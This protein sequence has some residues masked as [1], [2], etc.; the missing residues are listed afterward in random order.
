MQFLF[1]ETWVYPQARGGMPDYA[2]TSTQRDGTSYIGSWMYAMGGGAAMDY[3]EKTRE[4]VARGGDPAFDMSDFRRFPKALA[5]CNFQIE[6]RVAGLHPLGV[7]DVNGPN[8]PYGHW[9]T[10]GPV[11]KQARLG[12][13]WTRDPKYAYILANYFG[14]K[15]ESPEDWQ[16]ILEAAK[17]VANPW[18]T[19]RSRVLANWGALLEGGVQHTD[20]RYRRAAQIRV[21]WGWGHQHND[22]LDLILWCHGVIHAAVGG[23]RPEQRQLGDVHEPK[24]QAS[25]TH[26]MVEIDGQGSHGTGQHRGYSW[27][28]D[29]KD[30]EGARYTLCE[31]FPSINHPYQRLYRRQAAL[32]DLNEGTLPDRQPET[33]AQFAPSWKLPKALKTPDAYVFDVVRVA[34]GKRHTYCFHGCE[35]DEFV[36]NALNVRPVGFTYGAQADPSPEAKYLNKFVVAESKTAGVAPKVLEATWRLQREGPEIALTRPE[37]DAAGENQPV[38]KKTMKRANTEQRILGPNYDP[39]APRK[40]TRLMLFDREGDKVLTGKWVATSPNVT[41]QC[42]FAQRDLP[43]EL[44]E[45]QPGN[46]ESVYPAVIE[47]Y[48]GT[49]VIASARSVEIQDNESDALRAAA[50][51]LTLADGRKD[52]CFSGGRA[53]RVRRL[54]GGMTASADFAYLSTDAAGLRQAQVVGGVGLTHPALV[55]LAPVAAQR[56]GKVVEV[57]YFDKKIVVEGMAVENAALLKGA[58]VE[59]GHADHLTSYTVREASVAGRRVTLTL[60]KGADFYSSRVEDVNAATG[61]VR[62]GLGFPT[63]DSVVFPGMS[64]GLVASNE[65]LTRFWRA[66]FLG[67]TREE[68]YSFKLTGAP[69]AAADFGEK[70][71]LRI[72]EFGV[73]DEARIATH[74]ALRRNDDGTWLFQGDVACAVEMLGGGVEL[75]ADGATWAPLKSEKLSGNRVRFTLSEASLANGRLLLRTAK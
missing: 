25:Y 40:Y 58:L 7:G 66:E 54:A 56:A 4:Y 55:S 46:L 20:F 59:L 74:A 36:S 23:E 63:D 48:A 51:E 8:L 29:L 13:A 57:S 62:C 14:Q 45:G 19:Q 43:G 39:D 42:L 15:E 47:M 24:N 44:P 64:K 34:G 1:R 6:A 22:P 18:F 9:F 27:A 65:A 75:S 70:G 2:I 69:V 67:G 37:K 71:G 35:E 33:P 61:V 60:D 17:G 12:W 38:V 30:I 50:I 21:G 72:W 26:N 53:D 68:G 31:A 16:A 3:A 11:E 5:G 73:G 32:I 10:L 52:L 28:R 49:P 41:L